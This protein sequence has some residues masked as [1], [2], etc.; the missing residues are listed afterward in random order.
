MC[1]LTHFK[2]AATTNTEKSLDQ[3]LHISRGAGHTDPK[4]R[5]SQVS[6]KIFLRPFG[7]QF[8]L[9]IKGATPLDPPLGFGTFFGRNAKARL[10]LQQIFH[11]ILGKK[12]QEKQLLESNWVK[13][14]K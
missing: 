12:T 14:E 8:G 10:P 4:T 7:H 6:K 2:G 13:I 5:G 11:R 9:K 1:T 3:D